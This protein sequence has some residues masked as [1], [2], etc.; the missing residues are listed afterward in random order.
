MQRTNNRIGLA[1]ALQHDRLPVAADVREQFNSPGITHQHTAVVLVGERR[2]MADLRNHGLMAN[3]A[4]AQTK[5]AREFL[6]Q[7]CSLKIRMNRQLRRARG[8]PRK[9][10]DIRHRG[11]PEKHWPKKKGE[12]TPAE[13]AKFL[14]RFN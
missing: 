2:V 8:E 9:V 12:Y 14:I 13:E 11:P 4:R 1:L 6:L 7:D 10:S 3:V 5:Q